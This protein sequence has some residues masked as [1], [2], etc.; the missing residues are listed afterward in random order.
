MQKQQEN[1]KTVAKEKPLVKTPEKKAEPPIETK[2]T[3]NNQ[4]LKEKQK[5]LQREQKKMKQLEENLAKL[6]TRQK[7]LEQAMTDPNIYA[8]PKRFKELEK[9]YSQ[10][11][12]LYI[13]LG[14]QLDEVLEKVI[15]L[16]EAL[17]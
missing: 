14:K 8:D 3:A 11:N 7:E 4:A 13:D 9:E 16:E 6:T 10:N 5:D 1:T 15:L 2:S 12:Q 17:N